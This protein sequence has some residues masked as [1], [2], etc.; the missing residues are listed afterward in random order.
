[1]AGLG[2]QHIRVDKA[3]LSAQHQQHGSKHEESLAHSRQPLF[4]SRRHWGIVDLQ[5]PEKRSPFAYR[6]NVDANFTDTKTK[7]IITRASVAQD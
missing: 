6:T 4:A 2:R 7:Q 5:T 3:Q 1:M